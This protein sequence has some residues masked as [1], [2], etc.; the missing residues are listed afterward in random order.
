MIRM[1]KSESW[2]SVGGRR[3]WLIKMKQSNAIQT[4]THMQLET[5]ARFIAKRTHRHRSIDPL[6][7]ALVYQNLPRP[8]AQGLDLPLSQVLAPS[9][10]F[11]LLV[12]G[13]VTYRSSGSGRRGNGRCRSG[14]LGGRRGRHGGCPHRR[15]CCGSYRCYCCRRHRSL[16]WL[17]VV[18]TTTK[19]DDGRDCRASRHP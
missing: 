3:S 2:H 15:R 12:E 4:T 16:W 8:Q 11:N 6:N 14:M 10:P 17:R 13:G 7:V 1:H 19:M 9:Q 5:C 18:V